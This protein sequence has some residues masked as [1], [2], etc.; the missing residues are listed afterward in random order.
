MTFRC[1]SGAMVR[2][3]VAVYI[4]MMASCWAGAAGSS[5]AHDFTFKKRRIHPL[6]GGIYS[7]E[8]SGQWPLLFYGVRKGKS[9]VR[10]SALL[11]RGKT[12]RMYNTQKCINKDGLEVIFSRNGVSALERN[13]ASTC[14]LPSCG[15]HLN[16]R[17][18]NAICNPNSKLYSSFP[19]LHTNHIQCSY[20]LL[21]TNL[22]IQQER[23]TA[24]TRNVSKLKR[25][26][27]SIPQ[28]NSSYQ[29]FQTSKKSSGP[30]LGIRYPDTYLRGSSG[31]YL[32]RVNPPQ[33]S[34][35]IFSGT[36][37]H[38]RYYLVF[39]ARDFALCA[40]TIFISLNTK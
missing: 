36:W 10:P 3:S 1:V 15:M 9:L 4:S 22:A 6:H 37:V 24:E 12:P 38:L 33:V 25:H 30:V 23:K 7:H 11:W 35:W 32:T 40:V 34:T 14:T 21:S 26:M 29:L 20:V 18:F 17:H 5:R 28:S 16:I 2:D 39:L 13:S 19:G 31:K 8:S 27:Y